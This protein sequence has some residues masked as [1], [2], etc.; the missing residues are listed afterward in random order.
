[1]SSPAPPPDVETDSGPPTNESA[2]RFH[3][4]VIALGLLVALGVRMIGFI[5]QSISM[6]E[7]VEYGIASLPLD[8]LITFGNSFPPLYHLIYKVWKSVWTSAYAGRVLSLLLGL[9]SIAAIYWLVFKHSSDRKVATITMALAAISPFHTF[10]SQDGRGYMLYFLLAVLAFSTG[11]RLAREYSRWNLAAFVLVAVI[12]AYT[13]YYF[14]IVLIAVTCGIVAEFGVKQIPRFAIAALI[15][16]VLCLPELL[17]LKNDLD[18][19]KNLRE[20]RPLN[21]VSAG[22]TFFSFASG[23]S[24]GPSKSDLHT[25]EPKQAIVQAVPWIL[26][27][28][29]AYGVPFIAGCIALGRK[30]TFWLLT[31]A[32]PLALFFVFCLALGLTYN[33]RFAVW[34]WVPFAVICAAGIAHLPRKFAAVIGLLIVVL[35]ATAIFN[36][37]YV[38]RYKNEDVAAVSEYIKEMS[39]DENRLPLVVCAGYMQYPF[40]AYLNTDV[41]E[42]IPTI[43]A[44]YPEGSI[45]TA[46]EA[47]KELAPRGFWFAY[48]RAFHADPE[49]QIFATVVGPEAPPVL[50]VAGIKLYQIAAQPADPTNASD[51]LPTE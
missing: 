41:F 42:I 19:Q 28:G 20:A 4:T 30:L 22:Y 13:H 48:S 12:G 45:E 3:A 14:A 37:N 51:E 25:M 18:F 17:L 10:Y 27:V 24:L 50:E 34:L 11:M 39:S 15:I 5:P 36:R 6:D 1:M 7:A 9:A 33:P 38:D 29:L 21:V 23:H 8:E 47:C 46:I 49:G 2:I 43:D 32:I 44:S 40:Q 35:S 16:G 26:L 31:L